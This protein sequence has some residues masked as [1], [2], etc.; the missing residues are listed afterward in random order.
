MLL[1]NASRASLTEAQKRDFGAIVEIVELLTD[2]LG[3]N[4][5]SFPA[6]F[7]RD[8][9]DLFDSFKVQNLITSYIAE[10]DDLHFGVDFV[11]VGNR[12]C[13]E[14]IRLNGRDDHR[15]SR[16]NLES[17]WKTNEEKEKVDQ[18]IRFRLCKMARREERPIIREAT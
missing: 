13:P 4:V 11:L 8:L 5:Q 3:E 10:S 17:T 14:H 2:K 18:L 12:K 15:R 6:N 7:G 9:E 1:G 16:R